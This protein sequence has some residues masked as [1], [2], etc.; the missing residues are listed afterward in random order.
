MQGW[1][2]FIFLF[3][4]FFPILGLIKKDEVDPPDSVDPSSDF[5]TVFEHADW[6]LH[7]L[8]NCF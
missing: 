7:A 8:N 5:F 4:F 6:I 1:K 3:N 2:I